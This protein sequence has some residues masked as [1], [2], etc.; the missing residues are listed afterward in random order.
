VERLDPWQ[1]MARAVARD[2]HTPAER[3]TPREA[4]ELFTR[5]SAYAAGDEERLG[6]LEPGKHADFLVLD[7]DP[8]ASDAAALEAMR[9]AMTFVGGRRVSG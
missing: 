8:F 3:L 4:M 1:A 9:P 2:E 6:T 5:G 7:Q